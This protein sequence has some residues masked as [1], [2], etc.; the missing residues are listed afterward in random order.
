L[1]ASLAC[2]TKAREVTNDA[3]FA[4]AQAA[5]IASTPAV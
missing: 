2:S 3:Q 5:C 4:A 1:S